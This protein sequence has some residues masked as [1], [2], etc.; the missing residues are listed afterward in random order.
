MTDQTTQPIECIVCAGAPATHSPTCCALQLCGACAARMAT[1]GNG[2]CYG[3]RRP[4]ARV[5]PIDRNRFIN[6]D[7]RPRIVLRHRA[8]VPNAPVPD[9]S[10]S[11]TDGF[12]I[13]AR[14]TGPTRTARPRRPRT[15]RTTRVIRPPRTGSSSSSPPRF[16]QRP[17]DPRP[18]R[19]PDPFDSTDEPTTVAD[20]DRAI[21]ES[22]QRS[23]AVNP[24][25]PVDERHSI[26]VA[27][28]NELKGYVEWLSNQPVPIIPSMRM[29]C[30]SF[31]IRHQHL[32]FD[33]L[34]G[35]ALADN[36]RL[37]LDMWTRYID[38]LE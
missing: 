1:T 8:P 14:P 13:R 7:A 31:I 25:P 33:Q 17:Y 18:P 29:A 35:L 21:R 30:H 20:I 19:G 22:L 12:A 6:P 11:S 16:T 15:T 28:A 23:N 37:Y 34:F 32:A 24:S 10:S 27:Y 5:G 2:R 36:Q 9:E 3:C 26:R 38:S 4:R